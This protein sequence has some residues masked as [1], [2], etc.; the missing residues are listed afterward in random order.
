MDFQRL[1]STASLAAKSAASM[2]ARSAVQ[3]P[4]RAFRRAARITSRTPPRSRQRAT[5]ISVETELQR[6]HLRGISSALRPNLISAAFASWPSAPTP[7]IS[8]CLRES[9]QGCQPL[10]AQTLFLAK[11]RVWQTRAG[12]IIPSLAPVQDNKTPLAIT[13]HSSAIEQA[14]TIRQAAAIRLS[15][16][17]RE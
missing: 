6:V 3:C 14:S 7:Q 12:A 9:M 10:L 11:T 16:N 4:W 17:S 15:V 13:T 8:I 5:S 1:A 2:A